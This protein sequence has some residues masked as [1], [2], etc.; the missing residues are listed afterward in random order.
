M[1]LERILQSQGFGTRK[2]CRAMIRHGHCAIG[3]E[4]VE[5]PFCE[6]DPAGLEFSLDGEPWRFREKAYAMLHKP[7]DT[8]CSR[9]PRGYPGVLSLLPHP[10]FERG[11]QSVG[12]LDVDTTGLLLL[13]DDG[14]FIHAVTSP[15]RKVNKIY[16][17]TAKHPMTAEMLQAL[18]DGV[19]LNDAPEPVAGIA[20]TPISDTVFDLTIREGRYH[21][22]KRMVAAVGNRVE[23]LCRIAVGGLELPADLAPG[24]WKWLE[25]DDL[26]KVWRGCGDE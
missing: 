18:V 20:A 7:M 13:T 25:A 12:R 10:C 16:R 24:E 17:V 11:M 26:E 5:D 6:L 21:Q 22:V 23:S 14:N 4:I 2:E 1:Q 8:E 9:S 19:V 15:K 3:G